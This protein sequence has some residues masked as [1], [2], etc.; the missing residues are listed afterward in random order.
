MTTARRQAITR[1]AIPGTVGATHPTI[2]A[3]RQANT[4]SAIPS[5]CLRNAR[6]VARPIRTG[7]NDPFASPGPFPTPPGQRNSTRPLPGRGGDQGV[8]RPCQR[9]ALPRTAHVW[10]CS[11]QRRATGRPDRQGISGV[12]IVAVHFAYA[13]ATTAAPCPTDAW[14]LRLVI[15]RLAWTL[16]LEHPSE[17]RR[18]PFPAP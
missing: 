10:V 9:P 16:W 18:P 2:T 13:A 17:M 11:T 3:R 14:P 5:S 12:P 15:V 1:S 4:P 8:G 6:C 7:D